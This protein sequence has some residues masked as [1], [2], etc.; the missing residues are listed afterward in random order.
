MVELTETQIDRISAEIDRQGLT[1]TGL[2]NELL[3]HVCCD[4]E[5][6]MESGM[7]FNDAYRKI[8]RQMGPRRIRQI[9]DETL[10]LISKKYRRMKRIMYGLGIAIPIIIIVAILLRFQHWPGATILFSVALFAMAVFF[11]PVFVMVRIRDTRRQ[12]EPVPV[13]LYISGMICGMLTVIGSLFKIQHMYGS[14]VLLTLGLGGMALIFL[15]LYVVT[16]IREAREKQEPLNLGYY[17]LGVIAGILFI[18]G[19][20]FKILHWPGAG[21]VLIVSWLMVAVILLPLLI[22]NILKQKENR[23][24]NLFLVILALSFIALLVL[25]QLGRPTSEAYYGYIAGEGKIMGQVDFMSRQSDVL[26]ETALES[27]PTD[28]KQVMQTLSSDADRICEFI[29][30]ARKEMI[31]AASER[32]QPAITGERIDYFNVVGIDA[33][34]PVAEILVGTDAGGKA[35]SLRAMLEEFREIA[36]SATTDSILESYIETSLDLSTP[37]DDTGRDWEEYY[38]SGTLIQCASHL[39]LFEST[40]RIIEHELLRE[41]SS[42]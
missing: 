37:Q 42:R 9:Q 7:T 4:I 2:K 41:L 38:F 40:V 24:N 10:Y 17:I 3:D 14:A 13:G 19:A 1:Y 35:Y 15:P 29:E 34:D 30:S 21:M 31:L 22:L 39:T 20:L 27:I 12:N 6:E 23:V 36:R 25:S 26:M 18:A 11:L 32:N 5:A 33:R 8:R 16:R 28:K